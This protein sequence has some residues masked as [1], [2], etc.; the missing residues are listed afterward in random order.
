MKFCRDKKVPVFITGKNELSKED[1][2]RLLQESEV[3]SSKYQ[4]NED[5]FYGKHKILKDTKKNIVKVDSNGKESI[6]KYKLLKYKNGLSLVEIE[7]LTGRSHQ[8]RV[9]MSN[10]GHPL[11]GDHKYNKNAV[12]GH[13]IALFAKQIEFIHPT[14]K[15]LLTFSIPLPDRYPFNIFNS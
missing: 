12:T 5:Y 15:K 8:I 13:Q 2:V 1:V 14:T 11:V 3:F 6:L 4:L 7:L 10:F 9:Q